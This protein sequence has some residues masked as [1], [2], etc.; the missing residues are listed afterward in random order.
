MK[1]RN[2]SVKW[3]IF[4]VFLAFAIVLL[5]VLWLFQ[6]V[7]LDDFYK[8]IKQQETETILNEV[9][10][11]L[12][13]SDDPAS[14][15]DEIAAKNNIAIYITDN[16]GQAV[17]N[18]EYIFN[19]KMSSLPGYMFELFYNEAVAGGGE[20]TVQYKGSEMV[21]NEVHVQDQLTVTPNPAEAGSVEPEPQADAE[22]GAEA[23]SDA[24][25]DTVT[26]TT[27]QQ[28]EQ[29]MDLAPP[30]EPTE[31]DENGEPIPPDLTDG[32]DGGPLAP[33]EDG[34]LSYT[35]QREHHE[36]HFLQNM[37]D[38]LAESIIYVRILQIKGEERVLMVNSVLTPVDATVATLKYQ[39][40]I[41]TIIMVLIAFIIAF[42]I[43]RTIS[44]S[45][46]KLN[47]GAGQLAQGN[48]DV[49][50]N[51]RDYKEISQL[52][53]T[54]NYAAGELAKTEALQQEL[55][56]NVSHDLR[57]PLTMIKGY[58]EVMRDI[59]GENTPENVQV[60]IDETEHLTGL[61]NDMLD[62]SKLKAGT[63][64]IQPETYDLTESIKNVLTRYNKLR[65]VEGYTIDFNYDENVEIYA[66]EQ[67]M[68]QVIYNLI[69]NAINYTGDDKRVT[70]NQ[71]IK[72]DCVR[73]EVKD[74]GNGVS[75]EDIPYVWDRYYKDRSAHKRALQGTGLGLSIVKK[76]LELHQARYG[77]DSVTGQ[78][79]TFWF[80]ISK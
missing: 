4:F 25:A 63:I 29:Q 10:D 39:L 24:D 55:I 20:A 32:G 58:A 44:R 77:V 52:S 33:V 62:I 80:E 78:G 42:V 1:S 2:V 5:G 64:E 79:A 56:A 23:E 37:G 69:N 57:T 50:F 17:Y 9:E 46:I 41:I 31:F 36:E 12:Y 60:V 27:E 72:E 19:S 35:I 70:V 15:V 3:K 34:A 7:Y 76:V 8:M 48:Y 54:L 26:E 73:I 22:P 65:E 61:V 11:V 75:E 49:T 68:F 45:I 67:K 13:N 16:T 30:D 74:T 21:K 66:D 47:E 18:A 28:D 71:I 40:V 51:S 43:A 38:D 6:I 59:P 14:D 53:D